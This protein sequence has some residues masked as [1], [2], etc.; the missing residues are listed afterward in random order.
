M[1]RS[2][3]NPKMIECMQCK[4]LFKQNRKWQKFC[5][6]K[7]QQDYNKKNKV[8]ISM[9]EWEEFQKLLGEKEPPKA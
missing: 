1:L 6:T 5:S 3:N 4:L 7:C 8:Q 2:M 9:S